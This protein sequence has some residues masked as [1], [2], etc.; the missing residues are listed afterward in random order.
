MNAYL[1]DCFNLQHK[2]VVLFS[3]YGSGAGVNRCFNYMQDILSK[4]GARDFKKF[5]IQQLKVGDAGFINK[6]ISQSLRL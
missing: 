1:E 5:S 3:T 6:I 2:S 4:K